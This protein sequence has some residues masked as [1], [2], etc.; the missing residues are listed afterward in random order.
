MR[1][2]AMVIHGHHQIIDYS[3]G[4]PTEVEFNFMRIWEFMRK[5]W[6]GLLHFYHV[7]PSGMPDISTKDINCMNGLRCALGIDFFFSVVTYK[8]DNLFDIEHNCTIYLKKK[9]EHT[10]LYGAPVL[11]SAQAL[12]LKYLAYGG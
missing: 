1:E 2:S 8:T 5:N 3:I 12:F 7:H 10:L 9:K 6:D 4:T 11:T